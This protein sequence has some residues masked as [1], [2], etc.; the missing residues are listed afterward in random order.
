MK[1]LLILAASTL[2]LGACSSGPKPVRTAL[3]CPQS[4]GELTR[5]QIA[6]D[7]RS[8]VYRT[9]RGDE[10]TLQLVATG[11]DPSRALKAIEASLTPAV[12]AGAPATAVSAEAANAVAEDARRAAEEARVDAEKAAAQAVDATGDADVDPDIEVAAS[13]G[14]HGESARIRLPGLHIDAE[15][16][17][18]DIRIGGI[19]I[20]AEGDEATIR[21]FRDVRLKGEAFSRQKRGIRATYIYAGRDLPGGYKAVG[22]EAGGPK[23]GPLAVAMVRAR[24][25]DRHD[26]DLYDDVKRLVRRNGGV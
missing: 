24:E 17:K 25:A 3:E 9:A 21:M 10:V 6:P 2:A 5:A 19:R 4:E 20:N 18:A 16:D 8:C 7:G 13:D 11:G 22:Y 1:T 26:G 12:S 15:D 14:N 23:A